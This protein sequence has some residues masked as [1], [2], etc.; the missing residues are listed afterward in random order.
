[1][2]TYRP[3][4]SPG[5][6]PF[7]LFAV[8][9]AVI[10]FAIGCGNGSDQPTAGV[11]SPALAVV[12]SDY[13]V[14]SVALFDPIHERVVDDCVSSGST[15]SVLTQELSGDVVLPSGSQPGGELV[16]IDRRNA[17]LTFVAPRSCKA[18]AQLSLSTG[19][20]KSNP[21][22]VV[23]VSEQKA[24]VTR[25]DTNSA[26]TSDPS[27]FDEG[28]DLLIVDPTRLTI[29]GR[30]ALSE[31]ATQVPGANIRANPDRAILAEGHVYVTLN[32]LDADLRSAAGPGRVLEIDPGTDT[33]TSVIDLASWTGCSGI[34][35]APA[36][37]R[38][39]VAC[40]GEFSD[41]ADQVAKSAL[42]EI[43][44]SGAKPAVGRI[45]PARALGG[46]PISYSS[47]VVLGDTA[48]IATLG[49]IDFATQ[50]TLV[51]DGFY[52]ASLAGDPLP[53]KLLEGGA[54]NLGR[55]AADPTTGK[56]FLPDGDA[57]Q[58]RVR[59]LTP[60]G[61]SEGDSH[62]VETNPAGHLPPREIGWY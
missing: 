22:D 21:H 42:V 41:G 5:S 19:G 52:S 32:N 14:T 36:A 6:L 18:R 17:V 57:V 8:V 34:T 59:I 50:T 15:G 23:V 48:F 27:D 47:T 56:V 37:K 45:I 29:V 49:A 26:P 2:S 25:Y 53:T 38:L 62:A 51:A 20:F 3:I 1:M 28:D 43:D 13:K 46:Q 54:Y 44:V 33:V 12:S 60:L 30:I 7:R 55:A 16:V 39:Y 58:P 35:Y 24:Y 11:A 31:Y 40:G 9:V 4:A 61:M 10:L